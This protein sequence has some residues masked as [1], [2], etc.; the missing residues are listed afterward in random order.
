[1]TGYLVT[2]GCL[3]MFGAA[4]F[5]LASRWGLPILNMFGTMAVAIFFI[6]AAMAVAAWQ[7]LDAFRRLKTALKQ[8]EPRVLI[9]DLSHHKVP[10]GTQDPVPPDLVLVGPGG[11]AAV[12]VDDTPDNASVAA[13]RKRLARRA[14]RVRA[15]V[16]WLRRRSGENPPPMAAALVL[17]RR[18]SG[19]DEAPAG[20]SLVNPEVISAWLEATLP[21]NVLNR[22]TQVRL[23]QLYRS[24]EL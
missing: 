17:L 16:E 22:E 2:L 10:K 24:T 23:T 6:V 18:Q 21:G 19:R 20:V 1:M 15:G 9:S 12:M 13:A 7:S 4:L 8:M 11:V 3:A 14:A 5:G